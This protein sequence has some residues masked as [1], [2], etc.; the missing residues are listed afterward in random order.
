MVKTMF[1]RVINC[2]LSFPH[3]CIFF[4]HGITSFFSLVLSCHI[5]GLTLVILQ[6]LYAVIW[7]CC[8]KLQMLSVIVAWATPV[9]VQVLWCLL[10][11]WVILANLVQGLVACGFATATALHFLLSY[12]VSASIQIFCICCSSLISGTLIK[13][14]SDPCNN[15][16]PSPVPNRLSPTF[17]MYSFGI[18]IS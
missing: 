17:S 2:Y 8:H 4:H 10:Q 13:C 6:I 7:D 1:F 14:I 12:L 18:N 3:L 16:I 9:F 11:G 5:W 15:A